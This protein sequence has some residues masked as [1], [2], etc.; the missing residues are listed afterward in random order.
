MQR[1]R[2][3]FRWLA[4]F[5]GVVLVFIS[6]FAMVTT[7]STAVA[8]GATPQIAAGSGFTCGLRT[9]GTVVCWGSNSLGAAIPPAGLDLDAPTNTPTPVPPVANNDT[10]STNEDTSVAIAV[11][12]N[13]TTSVGTL[14]VVNLTQP[15]N[16]TAVLNSNG[17]I[18]YTPN[19]NYN[20]SGSFTYR[21]NNGRDT[22]NIATVSIT[23]APVNDAPTVA[24][25]AGTCA[26]TNTPTGSFTLML[27]DVESA[28]G[29]LTLSASSSNTTLVPNS[30]VTFGGSG[31]SRT[32]TIKANTTTGTA[33]VRLAVSD[34]KTSTQQVITVKEGNGNN[35][36]VTGTSDVDLL[37]G[38]GGNDTVN[39]QDGADLLCGGSGNDTLNGGAGNDALDGQNGDDHLNGN[40][41]ND[42]LTGG[43]SANRF[44]GGA[45]TDTVTDF[46]PSEGD[47][48]T[49]IP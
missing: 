49:N 9:N 6:V 38:Q 30:S 44:D 18:A 15:A 22:S 3:W 4:S 39:G 29:S 11:L 17:T 5:V 8:A 32:V 47:T 43:A 21:V 42:R 1:P 16:G 20:G 31:A 48:Q 45:N 27:N 46:K 10:A 23:V 12:A 28:P 13:D 7:P 26:A 33:L 2:F 40:E 37:F 14:Q 34:G 19:A 41:G 35:E 24:L 36:T 25:A